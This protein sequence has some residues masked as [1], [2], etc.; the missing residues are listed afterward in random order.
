VGA[1]RANEKG[2]EDRS[3]LGAGERA[4]CYWTLMNEDCFRLCISMV[5]SVSF[6]A[7]VECSST[8]VRE[9]GFS[10]ITS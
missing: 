6:V 7:G 8:S 5:P 9:S 1:Q 10:I 3:T 2:G 4:F